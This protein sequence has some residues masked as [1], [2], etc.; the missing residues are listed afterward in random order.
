VSRP[1]AE[2]FAPYYERYVSRVPEER[3][4]PVL[5]AQPAE[6]RALLDRCSPEQ[7]GFRYAPDKWS[8][9][10]VMSHLVDAERVFGYRAFTF[11]RDPGQVLPSFDE[12]RFV[13]ESRADDRSL[14]LLLEEWEALR[15]SNIAM[16]DRLP[17]EQWGRSGT[18][19]GKPVTVRALAWITAGHV[20]H[21]VAVLVERYGLTAGS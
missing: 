17:A 2:E 9:R 10:Q 3:I 18:A 14:A 5:E 7:E 4:M 13:D 16:F 19:S 6:I 20:R 1:T 8:I 21:H 12:N 11:A 15:R